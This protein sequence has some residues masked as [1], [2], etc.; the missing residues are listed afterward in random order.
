M[1]FF[2]MWTDKLRAADDLEQTKLLHFVAFFTFCY[3][4]HI[5]LHQMNETVGSSSWFYS[6]VPLILCVLRIV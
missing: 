5:A 6:F 2:N 3:V 1:N 4:F